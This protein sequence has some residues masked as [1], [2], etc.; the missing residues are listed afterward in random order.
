MKAQTWYRTHGEAMNIAHTTGNLNQITLKA[1]MGVSWARS[2]GK[3]FASSAALA[4]CRTKFH[5][6]SQKVRLT[7]RATAMPITHLMMR[8]RSSSR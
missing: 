4:G 5:S 2:G 1:S 7:P 8:E 3:W 6:G